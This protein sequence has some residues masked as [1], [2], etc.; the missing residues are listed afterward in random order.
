MGSPVKGGNTRDFIA[1][2]RQLSKS[3]PVYFPLGTLAEVTLPL[4][5]IVKR[6]FTPEGMAPEL[7]FSVMKQPFTFLFDL[8]IVSMMVGVIVELAVA[9]AG[10]VAVVAGLVLVTG[11]VVVGRAGSVVRAADLCLDLDGCHRRHHRWLQTQP[12]H[13]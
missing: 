2:D 4:G 3:V 1:P 13:P 11:V 5:W 6:T 10:V 7:F 8:M 12:S 9:G